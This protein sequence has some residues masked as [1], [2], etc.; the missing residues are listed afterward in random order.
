MQCPSCEH[1]APQAEFGDPLR[2]PK[3][4]AYYDKALKMKLSAA[5]ASA[6]SPVAEPAPAKK[7]A[8]TLAA[9]HVAVAT[10]GLDGAQPVV[11]VDVQMRFWSM[12]VFIIK[13]ALASIPA[14]LILMFIFAGVLSFGGAGLAS[15]FK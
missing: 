4:G 3:C 14:L 5:L 8:F 2:C 15:L 10:R 1:E 7:P 11:V 12:V 13:W 9:D 6:A